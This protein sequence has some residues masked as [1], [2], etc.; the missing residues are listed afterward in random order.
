MRG[1]SGY[2][3][4]DI[5]VTI[6]AKYSGAGIAG[7]E[8]GDK[9]IFNAKLRDSEFQRPRVDLTAPPFRAGKSD[10][11]SRRISLTIYYK[12]TDYPPNFEL[13]EYVLFNIGFGGNI[14]QQF[15][16]HVEMFKQTGDVERALEYNVVGETDGIFQASGF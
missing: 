1:E 4:A 13:Y 10:S 14:P 12:G 11:V 6:P 2:T 9:F 5:I 16:L 15:V 3:N 8:P 7:F